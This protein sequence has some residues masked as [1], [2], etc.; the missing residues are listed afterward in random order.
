MEPR[1]LKRAE[2]PEAPIKRKIVELLERRG[3]FVIVT[4]GNAFQAG[5]PDIYCCH[6]NYGPRWI[7]VKFASKYSFTKDQLRVF[8]AMS[9][10]GI[11][12]WVLS[13]HHPITESELEFQYRLLFSPPNWH[14]YLGKSS[15]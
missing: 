3:F 15:R 2:G 7:E 4:H 9:A 1:G 11:P 14:S 8:P 13:L 6:L 10:K 12:I 5:L